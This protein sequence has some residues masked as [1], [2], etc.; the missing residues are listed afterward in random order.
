MLLLVINMVHR[1][2]QHAV[3]EQRQ[4]VLAVADS[5]AASAAL[6]VAAR[7][8]AGMQESINSLSAYPGLRHAILLDTRGE[9][10]AHSERS[11]RGLFLDP[12]PANDAPAVLYARHLALEVAAP[13]RLQHTTFGWLRIG[14]VNQAL[15]EELQTLRLKA[16]LYAAFATVLAAFFAH[17]TARYLTRRLAAIERVTDAVERGEHRQRVTLTGNDEAARLGRAINTMLDAL[18]R[19]EARLTEHQATLEKEVALRTSDLVLARDAAEAASR[20][21]STFLA[22]M[23]HE[24][25]TPMNA[26]MGMTSILRR[27]TSDP[28]AAEQL[29]KIDHASRHLLHIINDILDL[30]KIEAERLS[31]EQQV[32]HLGSVLENVL[33]LLQHR[34]SGKGLA[35]NTHIPDKLVHRQVLGDP[36]RI[37]Q[38]LLNLAGNAVKFTAHGAVDLELTCL[39]EHHDR[40]QLRFTVRDS[41]IGIAADVLPRLFR[42]FEQADNSTTR[43]HGGTGLGL[44]ISKRLVELMGGQIGVDSRPGAGSTFWFSIT[45]PTVSGP[46]R[47]YPDSASQAAE[48][49]LQRRAPGTRILLAEDEP[50]NREVSLT[51]LEDVGLSVDVAE[52]GEAAVA[53][54]RQ[55]DYALILMD[56]QMPR[57]NG[58]DASRAIRQ[59]PRHAATPILAMTANAFAE[60]RLACLEA[61]MNEHISKP[62]NPELLYATLVHWLPADT[63][64]HE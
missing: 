47:R 42:P 54:A 26:I 35:L 40:L 22:N 15:A 8:F 38:M 19:S 28:A 39:E 61:G 50:V 58:L 16:Y 57:M 29:G 43:E 6:W 3:N 1:Q 24:L 41:G 13:I 37:G 5:V 27:R 49:C 62:I 44:A 14:V 46:E 30:S 7:D 18:A 32:F 48:A 34:A 59:L 12:P 4:Q 9:I 2:E 56:I 51:L 63:D 25:R 20:A 64:R 10:L 55:N 53:L 23:S 17:L 31:L 21:K 52:D 11:R 36:A 45:L 33:S 60:D